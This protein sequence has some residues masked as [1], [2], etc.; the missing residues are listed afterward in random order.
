M[1]LDEAKEAGSKSEFTYPHW[2][3]VHKQCEHH[4]EFLA[5]AY[6]AR[7]LQGFCTF[8][9]HNLHTRG[10]FHRNSRRKKLGDK[11][12][13]V[14]DFPKN[15]GHFLK[16]VGRFQEKLRVF[17]SPPPTPPKN[18]V[19]FPNCPCYCPTC[20][21]TL[22]YLSYGVFSPIFHAILRETLK[23]CL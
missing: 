14:G 18:T 9:F 15:V 2:L 19:I 16:N 7:T 13:N 4:N 6:H 21:S 17:L 8:C 23:R 5:H 11:T 22:I 10:L 20:F 3:N 12:K 1:I